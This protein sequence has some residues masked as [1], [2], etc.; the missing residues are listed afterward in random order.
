M[1]RKLIRVTLT[2]CLLI[3]ATPFLSNA[4]SEKPMKTMIKGHPMYKVLEPGMIPAIFDPE[5]ISVSEADQFYYP[6][7]PLLAVVEG[8]T[9]KAY[10]TWHLDRHEIV[11]DSINGKAIA[12]TW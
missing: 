3:L 5:F 10:S 8:G 2:A 11:N 7:E 9:A 1:L 4:Q 12:A 6:E